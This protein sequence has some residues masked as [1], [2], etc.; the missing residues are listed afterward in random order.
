MQLSK[1]TA[2]DLLS[3]IASTGFVCVEAMYELYLV[4]QL[5]LYN[6][7]LTHYLLKYDSF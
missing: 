2:A 4:H 5:I 7:N 3:A 6:S 1:K